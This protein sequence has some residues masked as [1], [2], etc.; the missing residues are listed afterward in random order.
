[1]AEGDIRKPKVVPEKENTPVTYKP[2]V[3]QALVRDVIDS[4]LHM[5]IDKKV[6][7]TQSVASK[8]TQSNELNALHKEVSQNKSNNFS[9]PKGDTSPQHKSDPKKDK[10][11][12]TNKDIKMTPQSGV[13]RVHLKTIQDKKM[14]NVETTTRNPSKSR[15]AG[16]DEIEDL[17]E[18]TTS[19]R[20]DKI[21]PVQENV[22]K[23]NYKEPS[24]TKERRTIDFEKF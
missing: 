8:V 9:Q 15:A 19:H 23:H 18:K 20:E 24:N 10:K 7:K 16:T 13:A 3:A 2:D 5:R 11:D 4:G 6:K 14:M 17:L 1:M 12:K 21:K 22:H